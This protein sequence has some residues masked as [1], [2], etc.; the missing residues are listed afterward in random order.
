VNAPVP[1]RTVVIGVG[2]LIHT[3]DGLGIHAVRA[4]QV[5]ARV[6]RDVELI[7]GGTFGLELL[8]Y[9]ATCSKL[10]I[11][12]AVDVGQQ[13][14]V[15][16]RM[17]AQDLFGLPGGAS[18]HQLG[19]ADLLATLPLVSELARETVLL[20]VQ[21]ASTEWGTELSQ[22]V[23]KSLAELVDAAVDQLLTWSRQAGTTFAADA[24][25]GSENSSADKSISIRSI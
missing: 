19:V 13:P 11:L 8:A 23:A 1:P 7:D 25:D 2:N 24:S 21:P 9:L 18:V 12:D 17:A 10:L 15:L 3:D 16:V 20:G 6:P 22:P 5:D 14:G 4:L